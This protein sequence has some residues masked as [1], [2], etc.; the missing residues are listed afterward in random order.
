MPSFKVLIAGEPGFT[1][2]LVET[3]LAGE[4]VE[5]YFADDQAQAVETAHRIIPDLILLEMEMRGDGGRETCRRLKVDEAT[6]SIPILAVVKESDELQKIAALELGACDFVPRDCHPAEFQ[7]RVRC[8]LRSQSLMKLLNE[9][10]LMD[11]LTGLH[12]RRYFDQRLPAEIALAT[13]R[14]Q[15]LACIVAELDRFKEFN[16]QYGPA[17]GEEILRLVGFILR[18]STRTEDIVCRDGGHRFIILLPQT[19]HCGASML[20]ERL[21]EVLE[22]PALTNAGGR[23]VPMTASFGVSDLATSGAHEIIRAAECA[24]NQAK[25]AGRNR[26]QTAAELASTTC[27]EIP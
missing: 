17:M 10:A 18:S 20:A 4:S 22:A 19:S 3:Y 25:R 21:R 11:G 26:V 5:P 23:P 12:N 2:K 9:Q 16:D 15:P 24:L 6:R 27:T 14:E 7:A 8:V 13:R 1:H